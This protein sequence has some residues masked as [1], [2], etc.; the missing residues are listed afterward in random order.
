[1][2]SF[3]DKYKKNREN[4]RILRNAKRGIYPEP[5]DPENRPKGA[6]IPQPTQG[7]PLL[8]N[9]G[10]NCTTCKCNCCS[11]NTLKKRKH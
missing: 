1:M 5:E 4:S 10:W 2:S 9:I 11:H 6:T 7:R 8:F 3:Y